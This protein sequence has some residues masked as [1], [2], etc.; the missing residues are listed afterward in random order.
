MRIGRRVVLVFVVGVLGV[1]GL[2]RGEAAAARFGWMG[3]GS[4]MEFDSVTG[5]MV[6]RAVMGPPSTGGQRVDGSGG[7]REYV[8][9][10]GLV[11]G[12]IFVGWLGRRRLLY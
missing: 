1:V 11:V 4:L 3:T 5:R 2:G 6:V 7:V 12:M 10:V 9:G 8:G